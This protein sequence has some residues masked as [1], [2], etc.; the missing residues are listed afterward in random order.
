M[1]QVIRGSGTVNYQ[2]ENLR[3]FTGGLNL[4]D[5]K[6]KV[7]ENESPNCLNVDVNVEGGFRRRR[8]AAVLHDTDHATGWPSSIFKHKNTTATHVLIH[9]GNKLY[10]STG[11][12]FTE[13]TTALTD[14]MSG[15]MHGVS[16]NGKTWI[17]RDAAYTGR[18]WDG[19]T[20]ATVTDPA[21][22]SW[23]ATYGSGAG[24]KLPL[25]KYVAVHFDRLWVAN[26]KEDGTA[27]P[28]RV[29]FSHPGDAGSWKETDYIDIDTGKDGQAITAIVPV[30]DHL[31][32]FKDHSIYAIYGYD[33][34]TFQVVKLAENLGTHSQEAVVSADDGVYF[35]FEHDGVY[36]YGARQWAQGTGSFDWLFDK[37]HPATWNGEINMT[38]YT[39][40]QLGLVDKDLWVAYPRSAATTRDYVFVLNRETKSR[41]KVGSWTR[42]SL[43]CGPFLHGHWDSTSGPL[44]LAAGPS[45]RILKLNFTEGG[46]DNLDG[47]SA[48]D[49]NVYWM[50]GWITGGLPTDKKRYKR[51]YIVTGSEGNANQLQIAVMRDYEGSVP[52][53]YLTITTEA[54]DIGDKLIWDSGKWD[55]KLWGTDVF[56]GGSIVGRP[57][58]LGTAYSVALQIWQHPQYTVMF[59]VSHITFKYK[60]RPIRG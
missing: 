3:D 60:Q 21:P 27:Y 35:W 57:G 1:P 47:T 56:E 12:N 41:N 51:P 18:T 34:N 50:T 55:E 49:F 58:T 30:Q 4:V 42:Y 40:I 19:T 36:R 43:P 23:D 13:C 11:G 28:S 9:V 31:L 46:N 39:S 48:D 17:V 25:A 14:S 20:L 15:P 32:V 54:S 22:S 29:R 38:Y 24:T 16:Y 8:S 33:E 53:K 7:Q 6:F 44:Y 26:T 10:Y 52:V 2:I 37:L 45:D 5:D 59:D